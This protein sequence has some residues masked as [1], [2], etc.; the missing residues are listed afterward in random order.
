ME[1]GEKMKHEE[2]DNVVTGIMWA[3]VFSAMFWLI[4][5]L[6]VRWLN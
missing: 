4:V 2:E 5:Y 1:L 3:M 6:I